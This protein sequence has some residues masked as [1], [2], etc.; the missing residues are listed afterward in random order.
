MKPST[1]QA[2]QAHA[3]SCYPNECCGILLLVGKSEQYRACENTHA[4]G[5]DA[6]RIDP[7]V[8]ATLEDEGAIIGICHS[9]PDASSQPSNHDLAMCEASKL[10]WHILSWPEGDLRTITPTGET[11]PL[12][13]RPFV[14]GV[15]DCYAQV[16]DWYQLELGIE[17]PEFERADGWWEGE[18]ELYLD[19]YAGAGFSPIP[20]SD[21]QSGAL[22][23]GDVILMQIQAPRVNHA[24]VYIGN[25]MIQHHL[26]GRLSRRDVYGGYWQ[27]NTRL[28]VRRECYL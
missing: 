28:I 9:H 11:P 27:R 15:W 25:G 6:F 1:F 18:Q 7:Q 13:N 24:A 10:P 5:K 12:L 20:D 22:Q 2:F 23:V 8:F 16:K 21:L 26:Y 14:H 3:K 17:L 4:Q 19:N